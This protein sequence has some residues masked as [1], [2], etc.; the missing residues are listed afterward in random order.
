MRGSLPI[1]SPAV[2]RDADVV[3]VAHQEELRDLADRERQPDDAVASIIGRER[4]VP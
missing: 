3:P 1:S 2:D 4:Q